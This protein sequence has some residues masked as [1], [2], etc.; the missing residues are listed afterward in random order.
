MTISV[1][2]A[3]GDKEVSYFCFKR[4]IE[5]NIIPKL[6]L[7]PKNNPN[8]FISKIKL[9]FP[10]IPIITG[11]SF[12]NEEILN[13]IK[14]LNVDYIISIL[15]PY[16]YKK[17]IFDY[18]KIGILN[19]HPAY[20]PYNRGWNGV[21]WCIIDN[22]PIGCTL[23]WIDENIDTGDICFQKQLKIEP[24]YTANDIYK[25]LSII[26]KE[27]FVESL[28]YIINKTLPKI[29]QDNKY[30]TSYKKKDL[31][32]IREIKLTKNNVELIDKLR[33][34]T[35]N[36]IDEAAYFCKENKKYLIHIKITEDSI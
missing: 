19:L 12:R 22:T 24:H 5:K 4:L 9:E 21:S 15:Y 36:N 18:V 7:C 31:N 26:E 17:P 35:T 13:T 11:L 32:K 8:K 3:M 30:A 33:A 10:D 29:K 23:H 20:L 14:K 27:L 1:I 28:P 34:L 25:N 2:Y 6:I 16:I